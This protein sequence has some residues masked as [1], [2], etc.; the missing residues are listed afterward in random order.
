MS[1]EDF[2]KALENVQAA[3][4][5]KQAAKAAAFSNMTAAQRTEAVN[6]AISNMDKN[7]A[8]YKKI[9]GDKAPPTIGGMT[10]TAE[11]TEIKLTFPAGVSK[12]QK[13]EQVKYI[14]WSLLELTTPFATWG[15]TMSCAGYETDRRM[16]GRHLQTEETVPVGYKSKADLEKSAK[17]AS[18]A[19]KKAV[20]GA[21]KLF[22]GF[23]LLL[24][25][26]HFA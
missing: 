16:E 23:A 6:K 19:A 3:S 22:T 5:E 14:V 26:V 17:S 21:S 7:N 15:M 9:F 8:D 10:M 11:K 12:T 24:A 2:V 1:V 20:G 4:K 18:D 13:C 25:A